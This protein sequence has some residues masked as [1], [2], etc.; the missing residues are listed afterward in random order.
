M[1]SCQTSK[2]IQYPHTQDFLQI[3]GVKQITFEGENDS[4]RFSPDNQR[5]VYISRKRKGHKNTQVYEYSLLEEKERRV[6]FQDGEIRNPIYIDSHSF[7]YASSTDEIKENLIERSSANSTEGRPPMELYQSDLFGNEILRITHFPGHD[8][9]PVLVHES[10]PYILFTSYRAG[11][12]G[13]FKFDLSLHRRQTSYFLLQK[14]KERWSPAVSHDKKYV[15][16]LEKDVGEKG[17]RIMVSPIRRLISGMFIAKEK[18]K[19]IRDLAFL[20]R[21][22]SLIYSIQRDGDE[23]SHIEVFDFEKKC[24]QILLSGRDSLVQPSVNENLTQIAVTRLQPTRQI[25]TVPMPQNLGPCLESLP[26]L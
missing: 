22:N 16:W 9:E 23:I 18:E 2:A 4:P 21:S 7:L 13:I 10:K 17:I 12:L 26:S 19:E 5:L 15:A 1:S 3:D 6:T 11:L 20:P 14:D 8:S 25:Y 24:T